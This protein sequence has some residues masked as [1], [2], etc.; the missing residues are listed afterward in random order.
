VSLIKK[1]RPGGNRRQSKLP[2]PPSPSGGAPW[3]VK[4]DIRF[5]LMGS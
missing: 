5:C 2:S 4:C 1:S 3:S